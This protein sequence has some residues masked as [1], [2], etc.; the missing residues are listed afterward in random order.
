MINVYSQG[1]M[2]QDFFNPMQKFDFKS[3]IIRVSTIV[4]QYWVILDSQN[5]GKRHQV[6]SISRC[7]RCNPLLSDPHDITKRHRGAT[8][9]KF[10]ILG[11]K[12]NFRLK[13]VAEL[14]STKPYCQTKPFIYSFTS[15]P[16]GKFGAQNKVTG[17]W[18]GAIRQIVEDV[19]FWEPQSQIMGTKM[20]LLGS[21]CLHIR[22]QCQYLQGHGMWHA[23]CNK[24]HCVL[25]LDHICFK[26]IW[27]PGTSM[28][29]RQRS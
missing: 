11:D 16:D 26:L 24:I 13:Q 1:F 22:I 25:V 2:T 10:G 17:K 28:D 12:L 21:R 15:P 7:E 9:K 14:W 5:P 29:G 19:S 6:Y 20:I 8:V 27:V 23:D 4:N 18:N 3:H